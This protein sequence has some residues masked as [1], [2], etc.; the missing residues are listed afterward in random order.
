MTSALAHR[1]LECFCRSVPHPYRLFEQG[2]DQL[3]S[4]CGK[5]LL[6]VGCGRTVHV[7]PNYQHSAARTIGAQLVE[8]TDLHLGI[9]A[10]S[11]DFA[12]LRLHE[13]SVDLMRSRIVFGFLVDP[14]CESREFARALTP[15]DEVVLLTA[16]IWDCGTLV[17]PPGAH[18]PSRP[19]RQGRPAVRQKRHLLR[20]PC[21]RCSAG[22]EAS[23]GG[24]RLRGGRLRLLDSVLKLP[25][26]QRTAI[27]YR[28][29]TRGVDLA[30]RMTEL[31][32]RVNHGQVGQSRQSGAGSGR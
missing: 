12:R 18:T 24:Q 6:D 9:E 16:D 21:G 10:H 3:L 23:G 20:R 30:P 22:R 29:R 27:H 7:L 28:T 19:L 32:A 15:G 25:G 4:D 8:I 2:V 31:P 14:E 26:R 5:T 13:T 1:L 11:A 17:A